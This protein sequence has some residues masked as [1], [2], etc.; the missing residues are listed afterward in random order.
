M[1]SCTVY[2]FV[3][4]C[5]LLGNGQ[6]IISLVLVMCKIW[7]LIPS[8]YIVIF[9]WMGS[10]TQFFYWMKQ[11]NENDDEDVGTLPSLHSIHSAT[12]HGL[13]V[14]ECTLQPTCQWI[15][16]GLSKDN[17]KPEN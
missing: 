13:T 15:N 11:K 8:D 3:P 12:E 1:F 10:N 7:I 17:G 2:L 6:G 9:F 14:F 16:F 4:Q 5:K